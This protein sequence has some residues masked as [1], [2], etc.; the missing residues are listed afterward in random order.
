[1][2]MT[3]NLDQARVDF[4][5]LGVSFDATIEAMTRTVR[6]QIERQ[7]YARWEAAGRP[8]GRDLEFWL[9][10]ERDYCKY[11]PVRDSEACVPGVLWNAVQSWWP[12]DP[13][14]VDLQRR[15]PRITIQ[16]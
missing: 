11:L 12:I 9:A 7:A 14:R 1:M 15:V 8:E 5:R 13:Y 4:E 2:A 3:T 10:A 16:P 6:A